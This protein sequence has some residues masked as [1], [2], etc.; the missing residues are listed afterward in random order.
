[1]AE[2]E[3][4]ANLPWLDYGQDFGA[5]AWRPQ[6]GV[7]IPEREVNG[8]R[9]RVEADDNAHVLLRYKGGAKGLWLSHTRSDDTRMVFAESAIDA[10]EILTGRTHRVRVSVHEG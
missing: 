6:G 1:M 9:V 2:L 5:S 8:R 10:I 4:G 3:V 7:A